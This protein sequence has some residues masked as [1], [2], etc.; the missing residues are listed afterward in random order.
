MQAALLGKVLLLALTIL[1]TGLGQA[2]VPPQVLPPTAASV[3]TGA[4][5]APVD[6]RTVLPLRWDRQYRQSGGAR[7]DFALA[8]TGN[9]N[10]SLFLP[11]VGNVFS[12]WIDDQPVQLADPRGPR[13]I[14]TVHTSRQVDL[15][16]LPHRE[17]P[18]RL[19]VEI[20]TQVG[21]DGGLSQVL[22]GTRDDITR[23]YRD[24]VY[25][26]VGGSIVVT[27]ASLLLGALGF[28]VWSHQREPVY[29][30][31]ALAETFW[32]L[33]TAGYYLT[34]EFL[35]PWP[36]WGILMTALYC[37][38]I[39]A[40]CRFG[41][42]LVGKAQRPW[43]TLINGFVVA[44]CTL[45]AITFP[46]D[47]HDLWRHWRLAILALG[48]TCAAVVV[49]Q[50]IV[51]RTREAVI[52]SAACAAIILMGLRDWL[53]I[54]VSSSN[55]ASFPWVTYGWV[56]FGVVMALVLAAR[57]RSATRA[58][59]S[60]A[61]DMARRLT[62]QQAMLQDAFAIQKAQSE[63]Q[64]ATRERQRIL[65]DMH[66]GV[67]HELLG[68]FQ[69]A[70]ETGASRAMVAQQIQRA[71]DHLKLTVDVLQDGSQDI[72]TVLGL[73]RY[74][75]EPRLSAAGIT[76]D[77]QA[78]PLPTPAGW[79]T[80]Q[81]RDL[82]LLLY[83]A[84]TNLQVHS[85]ATRIR[86]VAQ[87]LAQEGLLRIALMDNGRGLPD[88]AHAHAGNGLVS[89]QTRAKR[90]GANLLFSNSLDPAFAGAGITLDIPVDSRLSDPPA[91]E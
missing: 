57:L 78:Q 62:E 79:G 38:A 74:R 81:A 42:Q 1:T 24:N 12:V 4:G 10:W 35:L 67:G 77:W 7:I 53:V 43:T 75:L 48:I 36:W 15:P 33:R 17:A 82:Q 54:T 52:M 84:F 46:L 59:A 22:Y 32:S 34:D 23:L 37:G 21:A 39:A 89:M 40:I 8:A 88:H 51:R 5:W 28:L 31:Y 69:V 18:Y 80:R 56:L 14:N 2:V 44:S 6:P 70:R 64:V 13:W 19:R 20:L 68:A 72:G 50:A 11:R 27:V 41:L 91:A 3:N 87:H 76:M 47:L 45:L 66:D 29:L 25:W 61:Q 16:P 26:R 85:G 73:L 83:E 30:Y 58:Q 49:H 60:H 63:Q 90:L 65:Q 86:F 71:M 55:Y 9:E